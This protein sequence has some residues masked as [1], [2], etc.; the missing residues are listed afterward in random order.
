MWTP[1]QTADRF[2]MRH[3]LSALLFLF[4]IACDEPK[5]LLP[6]L[7]D[8]ANLEPTRVEFIF[9][10]DA[11]GTVREQLTEGSWPSWSPDGRRI[12]FHRDGHVHVIGVDGVGE[13]RLAEGQ[14]PTW[15]PDGRWIAYVSSDGIS[16]MNADGSGARPLMSAA[17]YAVHAATQG[18]GKLSWSPD[19][20]LIAF[21]Q[22]AGYADG[23]PARIFAMTADGSKQY[24]ISGDSRYETEP[25]WSP[26]GSIIY[27]STGYGIGF[28]E[29]IGG[30]TVQLYKD[31]M[32]SFDARPVW[33]PDGSMIAFNTRLPDASILT[34]TSSGDDR[35]VLIRD[36]YHAAWSPDGKRIAFARLVPR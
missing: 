3:L 20:S 35:K 27:W 9:L 6:P 5:L 26:N 14:W 4:G 21:D 7:G 25:S 13:V 23:Y 29:R 10:A 19:G 15:S 33:S 36:G 2:R 11:D 1:D 34:I 28:V 22:P 16:V 8:P 18:V 30:P 17:L 24:P 31:D 32:V 12:V